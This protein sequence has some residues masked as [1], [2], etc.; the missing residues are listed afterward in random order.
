VSRRIALTVDTEHPDHPAAPGNLERQLDELERRGVRAT[1]FVQ[2]RWAAANPGPA[3][4]I[5]E[6][7]HVIGNLSI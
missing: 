5:A 3:R 7:G 4:R 2:G 1:L 6:A